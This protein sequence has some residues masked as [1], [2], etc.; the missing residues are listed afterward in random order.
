MKRIER[1]SLV[2]LGAVGS[3]YLARMAKS[4]PME[5]L[6]VIASGARAERYRS[7]VS[8]NGEAFYFP[9]YE[10]GDEAEPADLLIFAVKNNQLRQA[11][12][13]A[14]RHA[15]PKTVILSLLN[16]VASERVIAEGY[17]SGNVLCSHVMGLDAVRTDDGTVYEHL[18]YI[19]FGEDVNIPGSY[20]ENTLAVAEFFEK[21]GIPYRI[22]ENMTKELWL[23][24]MLNVGANQLSAVLRCPYRAIR[25]SQRVRSLVREA[26]AEAAAVS[27]YEGVCLGED[28]IGACLAILDKLSPQGKTSMLQDVE[29]GR[30][31]EVDVFGGTVVSLAQ[32][33]GVRVPL[34]E[35]LVRLILAMEETFGAR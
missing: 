16:G 17:G 26:M 14:K 29:A 4:V 13:D 15:G 1:V 12:S 5:N 28:D 31:T 2:G 27:A 7:G 30:R 21:S 18:G 19:T 25:E 33:H 22:P 34:N 20:S 9:V 24:F 10:P 11:I 8:V 23:K 35:M 6:R 32:K 3:S